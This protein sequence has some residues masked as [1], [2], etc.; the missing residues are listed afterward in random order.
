MRDVLIAAYKDYLNNYLSVE[1]YAEHNGL[2][3]AEGQAL[4]DLAREVINHDHPES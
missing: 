3:E 4:L 2:T 1:K